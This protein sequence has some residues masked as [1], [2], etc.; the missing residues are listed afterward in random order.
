M[1][2]PEFVGV[3]ST[4]FRLSSGVCESVGRPNFVETLFRELDARQAHNLLLDIFNMSII[5]GKPLCEAEQLVV[6]TVRKWPNKSPTLTHMCKCFTDKDLL[7]ISRRAMV[8]CGP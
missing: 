4:R 8:S 2:E 7:Q 1:T 6:S 3:L 5:V